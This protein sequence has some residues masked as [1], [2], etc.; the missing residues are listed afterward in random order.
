MKEGQ[1]FEEGFLGRRGNAGGGVVTH[2]ITVLFLG[3]WMDTRDT[4]GNSVSGL[5]LWRFLGKSIGL[6]LFV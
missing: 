4:L 6:S 5:Q 1:A 2:C 3:Y